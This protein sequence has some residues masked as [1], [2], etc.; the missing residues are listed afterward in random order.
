LKN[1]KR[2]GEYILGWKTNEMQII[3]F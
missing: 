2:K 3:M 1:I